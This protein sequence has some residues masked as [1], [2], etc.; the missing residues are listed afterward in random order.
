VTASPAAG[1]ARDTLQAVG[2]YLDVVAGRAVGTTIAVEDELLIGREA[3]GAGQ[4]ADDDE[5]SRSHARVSL[6]GAVCVIEDLGSTNGTFVNGLR[7]SAP[8]VLEAG[9]T[10]E[11][12]ESTLVVRDMAQAPHDGAARTVRLVVDPAAGTAEVRF[13]DVPVPLRLVLEDGAWR[14]A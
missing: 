11:L 2:V 5:I 4:L 8:Q 10:I 7:I 9:D 13:D 6:D 14:P 3:Q 1:A 12:G